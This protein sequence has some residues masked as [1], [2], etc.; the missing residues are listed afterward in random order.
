[1][2]TFR[3]VEVYSQAFLTSS[4]GVGAVLQAPAA[5]LPEERTPVRI[6]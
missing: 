3:G 4:L 5:F 2:Q 1:M 6:R